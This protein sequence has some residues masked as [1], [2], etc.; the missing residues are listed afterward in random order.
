M[1]TYVR[2]RICQKVILFILSG[3]I[4]LMLLKGFSG[5]YAGSDALLADAFHSGGDVL[6][7]LAIFLCFRYAS[8][9]PDQC[10]HFGHGKAEYIVTAVVSLL[11]LSIAYELLT[12]TL[13]RISGTE[14]IMVPGTLAIWASV[15]SLILKEAMYR[16][17]V[18]YGQ[19]MNSPALIADAW[20][21]RSDAL[22]SGGVLIGVGTARAGYPIMD[23][24][25]GLVI[26]V[27][28]LFMALRLVRQVL[29]G[30]LD[31]AP[32]TN[33]INDVFAI[34]KRIEGVK[35]IHKLRGR[36]S[37]PFIFMEVKVGVAAELSVREAYDIAH[38]IKDAVQKKNP[39][40]IDIIVHTNPV[41]HEGTKAATKG[42][43]SLY[44]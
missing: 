3:N 7:S 28:I 29:Q 16:F 37:G 11:L 38:K 12:S 23:P 35:E 22:V 10:H 9:P 44:S 30:L 31:T 19:K 36:Y 32:D 42:E 15:F 5:W 41:G 17:T 13:R 43:I 40:I 27:L 14:A 39:S 4:F 26:S 8:R 1:D 18:Y 33:V 6:A 34:I 25:V 21:H 24:L 20:H 2:G